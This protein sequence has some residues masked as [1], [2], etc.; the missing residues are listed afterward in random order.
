MSQK[1]PQKGWLA[2]WTRK[3]WS[4]HWFVL[5]SGSLTYYRGPAAE[6]CSFLDGVL[7]L[8][9]I[10]HI[11]VGC[12]LAEA[13]QPPSASPGPHHNHHRL[14]QHQ[15]QGLAS[16]HYLSKGSSAGAASQPPRFR[17]TLKMWN[18]E[19]HMLA[20]SSQAER[21]LWLQ[22]INSCSSDDEAATDSASSADSSSP[23]SK[24]SAKSNQGAVGQQLQLQLQSQQQ[25]QLEA[26]L[27]LERLAARLKSAV[28]R[29]QDQQQQQVVVERTGP[30]ATTN[31]RQVA[32]S[33]Q[34]NAPARLHL[35]CSSQQRLQQAEARPKRHTTSQQVSPSSARQVGPS[36]AEE[37]EEEEE[38][39]E[40]EEVEGPAEG[41]PAD[42]DVEED[43]EGEEEEGEEEGDVD[44]EDVDEAEEGEEEEG[45]RAAEGADLGE[46]RTDGQAVKRRL[47]SSSNGLPAPRAQGSDAEEL[48]L[49]SE[50]KLIRRQDT[51][52]ETCRA[53]DLFA[54]GGR[55]ADHETDM[56]GASSSRSSSSLLDCS[57][58]EHDPEELTTL[59]K[60]T[61]TGLGQR[62]AAAAELS[63]GSDVLM[64]EPTSGQH[65]HQ[66]RQKKR[67]TFDLSRSQH[68]QL[69]SASS[70][71]SDS[72]DSELSSSSSSS[73]GQPDEARGKSKSLG[74][75]I[76]RQI[77]AC[78]TS[79]RD[80]PR[81]ASEP[82]A[83]KHCPQ[84]LNQ[85][86]DERRQELRRQLS[87]ATTGNRCASMGR[88][89]DEPSD[90]EGDESTCELVRRMIARR[91]LRSLQRCDSSSTTT[92]AATCRQEASPAEAMA[93]D[94]LEVSKENSDPQQ[95][96]ELEARLR[97]A[98]LSI[99]SLEER[100]SDSLA[101][102]NQ[103]ESSYKRLQ[104]ELAKC[105]ELH[106]SDLN[107]WQLKVEELSRSLAQNELKL[108]E[109]R[110]KLLK[111]E[112]QLA[113]QV[114]QR[115]QSQSQG[116]ALSWLVKSNVTLPPEG[117]PVG[118]QHNN[119]SHHQPPLLLMHHVKH[120]LAVSQK[121]LG[122]KLLTHSKQIQRKLN[123]LE[124]K[125]DRIQ[126]VR[127]QSP[128]KSQ[129]DA[130]AAAATTTTPTTT[131]ATGSG[132]S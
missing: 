20:A 88:L 59:A 97:E 40:G 115:D 30:A 36:A 14:H 21:Q 54:V 103:L 17:F 5:K 69:T 42:S 83:T 124:L 45:E 70:S 3:Q 101:N 71:S 109:A 48:L 18:G 75:L 122:A 63:S 128:L 44:E 105:D 85:L 131:L 87:A 84:N 4:R 46:G 37:E 52:P 110:E 125:V 11:E 49:A 121:T 106:R 53:R 41:G 68:H 78:R 111:Y 126:S 61:A 77:D 66:Q 113:R 108:R 19:C 50:P 47:L 15:Q 120:T 2:R 29:R 39:E 107:R 89:A 65:E 32:G 33:E 91:K 127:Q 86:A 93:V 79:L 119:L 123:E 98:Q 27:S 118:H 58:S 1:G 7:D 62:D 81:D 26:E 112:E 114:A 80:G 6:L 130:A 25:Q 92:A 117:Q 67:V 24:P 55:A 116:R 64:E 51:Q 74:Q 94:S 60:S 22:A 57:D 72:S 76:N 95:R 34:P 132:S 38:E 8:S 90:E 73:S 13:G 10:K 12:E 129:E 23:A 35:N 96:Q 16:H 9:L 102:Y 104:G 82:E 31:Q 43:E 56:S 100:L 99:R 28:R